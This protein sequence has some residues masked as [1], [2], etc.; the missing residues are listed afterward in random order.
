[1][2]KYVLT[3]DVKN[4]VE[5]TDLYKK[6]E[7][8]L[9]KL[10]EADARKLLGLPEEKHKVNIKIEKLELKT[11]FIITCNIGIFKYL[12]KYIL[13]ITKEK[14]NILICS[15]TLDTENVKYIYYRNKITKN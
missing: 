4:G 10:E 14:C 9:F 13:S 15:I 3:Y 6:I 7:E 12:S 11:T 5:N 8:A 1:M 2:P